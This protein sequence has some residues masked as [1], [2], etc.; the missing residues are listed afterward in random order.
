VVVGDAVAEDDETVTLTLL[1]PVNATLGT[2]TGALTIKD[3]DS[4]LVAGAVGPGTGP[5]LAPRA[6]RR[7]LVAARAY[8]LARG[9][10]ADRLASV[11]LTVAPMTGTDL[12]QATGTRVVVDADAAGWGWR[13]VDLYAVLVHELGHV[14]GLGHAD[15]GV[16][17][18]RLDSVERA[19]ATGGPASSAA[20]RRSSGWS[21][22][23]PV[24]SSPASA[25][26]SVSGRRAVAVA[27][28][29]VRLLAP[30][31]AMSRVLVPVLTLRPD[32]GPTPPAP[33]AFPR[34]PQGPQLAVLLLALLAA[35]GALRAGSPTA[36]RSRRRLPMLSR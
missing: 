25:A 22:P 26:S 16:M 11:R 7:A 19:L 32:F 1:A 5:L 33:G 3:D 10:D 28:V 8:W 20:P 34:A 4:R 13:R 35:G 21:G 15:G 9:G 14:L 29:A 23:A 27:V 6:A 31:A 2:V 24:L 12:A 30:A 17:S 36:A 18:A